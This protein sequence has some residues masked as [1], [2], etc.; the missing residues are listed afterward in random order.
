[1]AGEVWSKCRGGE[2]DPQ[3]CGISVD[4]KRFGLES[5]FGLW[6]VRGQ[7]LRDFAALNKVETVPLLIR[8]GKGLKWDPWRLAG[9]RDEDLRKEDWALLDHIAELSLHPDDCFREIREVF[10]SMPDL[11]P[12]AEIIARS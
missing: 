6:F 4:P 7:L 2:I 1:M 11:Q 5:L 9:A 8:L 3:R 10:A 12:P